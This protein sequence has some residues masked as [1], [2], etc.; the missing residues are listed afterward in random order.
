MCISPS[1]Y[2][3]MP[4]FFRSALEFIFYF[5]FFAHPNCIQRFSEREKQKRDGERERERER[6]SK[7][8]LRGHDASLCVCVRACMYNEHIADKKDACDYG[9]VYSKVL[10]SIRPL[11][12]KKKK[13]SYYLNFIK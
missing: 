8:R 2:C 13:S 1:I 11:K 4:Y 9:T 10:E 3:R 6:E 12:K 5:I 7:S